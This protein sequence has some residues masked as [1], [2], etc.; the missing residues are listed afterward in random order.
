MTGT[1]RSVLPLFEGRSPYDARVGFTNAPWALLPL[2]PV[3]LLPE[4]VGRGVLFV[5]TFA[6]MAVAAVR[7]GAKHIDQLTS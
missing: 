7:L 3:A 5:I 1:L 4:A 6:V 2:L